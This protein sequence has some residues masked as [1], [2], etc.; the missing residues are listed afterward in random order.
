MNCWKTINLSKEYGTHRIY[1]VSLLTGLLSFIF[2]YLA[3][4]MIHQ[5]ETFKDHGLLPLLLGTA[6]IPA[7]HKL[8]HIVPLLLIKKRVK[9]NWKRSFRFFPSLSFLTKSKMSKPTSL[10]ILLAPTFFLTLPGVVASYFFGEYFAYFLIVTAFNIGYSSTD[11]L[12][13]Y[14]MLKAPKRCVV[15][16]AKDGYDI[17]VQRM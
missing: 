3:F 10:I 17:L 7:L 1:L 4:S 9:I 16:N 12:Y 8:T 5:P 11:F 2:L 14:Q 13:I 15:E 6:A